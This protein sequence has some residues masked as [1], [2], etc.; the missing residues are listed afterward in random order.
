MVEEGIDPQI[1]KKAWPLRISIYPVRKKP[2]IE[3]WNTRNDLVPVD[4]TDNYGICCG[5][6]S[7]NGWYLLVLDFESLSE[8]IGI[9][10]RYI[11]EKMLKEMLCVRSAHLEFHVYFFCNS[12]PEKPIRPAIVKDGRALMDLLLGVNS[13]VLG[14]GSVIGYSKCE[15]EKCPWKGQEVFTAY[16]H[17]SRHRRIAIVR[18]ET[19]KKYSRRS[20]QWD[21]S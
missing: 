10:W 19:L 2:K 7:A 12:V 1:H 6:K 9:L 11:F 8:A 13:A 21:T 4:F 18:K 20:K 14:P 16:E 17:I 5:E 15:S 3:A